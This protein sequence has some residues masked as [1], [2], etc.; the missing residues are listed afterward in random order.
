MT[1]RGTEHWARDAR[2]ESLPREAWAFFV[3][4]Q[5]DNDDAPEK[6]SHGG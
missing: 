5:S 3:R 4:Q 2:P 1:S 6:A